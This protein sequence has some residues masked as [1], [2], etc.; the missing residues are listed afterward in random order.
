M[1]V[2]KALNP[3]GAREVPERTHRRPALAAAG[4]GRQSLPR[5]A[6][7][8][9]SH[10]TTTARSGARSR[11]GKRAGALRS[12]TAYP[13]RSRPPGLLRTHRWK[14]E[15][16]PRSKTPRESAELRVAGVGGTNSEIRASQWLPSAGPAGKATCGS[17]RARGR[18]GHSWSLHTLSCP[19]RELRRLQRCRTSA[20]QRDS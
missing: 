4:F 5:G 2:R 3:P 8:P 18:C 11:A 15:F 12:G 6:P 17:G 19:P 20:L 7:S 14:P 16:A 9:G 1:G 13:H 10:K